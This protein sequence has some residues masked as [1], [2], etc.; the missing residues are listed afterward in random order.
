MDSPLTADEQAEMQQDV[1]DL[2]ASVQGLADELDGRAGIGDIFHSQEGEGW[3]ECIADTAFSGRSKTSGLARV[4]GL[5]SDPAKPFLKWD[6]TTSP[7]T[8]TEQAGPEPS[9]WPDGEV[10]AEKAYQHGDWIVPRI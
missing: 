5:N 8:C 1:A 7:P 6:F 2:L 3:D 10:W 9:I 4:D